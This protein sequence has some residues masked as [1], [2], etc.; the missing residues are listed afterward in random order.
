MLPTSS[1]TPIANFWLDVEL[2]SR[3]WHARR[4]P[5]ARLQRCAQASVSRRLPRRLLRRLGVERALPAGK[6][7]CDVLARLMAAREAQGE[8]AAALAAARRLL[9][10]DPLREDAH[11]AAMRACCRLGQRH[12]ALAQYR[13]LPDRCSRPSWGRADGR[14]P[15]AAPGDRRGPACACQPGTPTVA[16]RRPA[17]SAGRPHAIR[18]TPWPMCRWS[19]ASRSW[20]SWPTVGRP[21]S[22]ADAAC[23]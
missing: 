23:C 16:C 9:D 22:A 3:S 6:P 4:T 7:L 8:H 1:S 5:L 11:R 19:A 21:R 14:D 2:N 20:P 12:A 10:Q 17:A 18:W 13:A 15:G